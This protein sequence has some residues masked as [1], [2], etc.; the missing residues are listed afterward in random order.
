[1]CILI[2]H[3]A[4]T[5][6]TDE[7]LLDFYQHNPDGFG[8][9]YS[10]NG[11]LVV[12]KTLGKPDEI[13]AI[14]HEVLKGR[15][16][17][18]H[19]RMKTHGDID[20][21]N[22]HPYRVTDDIWMA[23]NGILAM[24]NPIDTR[25][26]D[27]WHFIEYILRP[28]LTGNPD[29]LFDKDFQDYIADMIGGSNKFAFMHS[30]GRSVILNE[31]AGVKHE[32]AWL[33]NTY[34]WSAAKYGHGY[35]YKRGGNYSSY[36]RPGYYDEWDDYEPVGVTAKKDANGKTGAVV[37]HPTAKQSSNSLYGWD[38]HSEI[39]T[40][41]EAFG[42]YDYDGF[43]VRSKSK[44]NYRKVLRAAYNCYRR[45]GPQLLDWVIA[46]PEKA[47]YLLIEW[48]GEHYRGEMAEMVNGSPEEAVDL[49]ASLFEDGS[50]SEADTQ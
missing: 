14:Y 46:A 1:M 49:I 23:H 48:Y 16:C 31:E 25:K 32:G 10:E 21:D 44:H 22:C 19:Y 38:K 7:L 36:Y 8:A 40:N 9:V 33:S 41:G 3:P 27:T 30:D 37:L 6:F 43:E 34:A 45:G 18:I 15:E 20:L 11:K 4:N 12:I 13:K 26:S 35:S 29:L 28:A 24:G 42:D 2:Q 39:D 17:I 5:V 50:V 47:E